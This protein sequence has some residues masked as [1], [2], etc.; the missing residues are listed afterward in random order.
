MARLQF[1]NTTDRTGIIEL[2]ERDTNTQSATASSYPLKVKTVDVN[3]ALGSFALLAIKASGR[4]QW[5]DTNQTDYPV[6]TTNIVSAQQDYTLLYDGATIP[7]QILDLYTVRV[8]NSAGVFREIK[9]IDRQTFDITKWDG[10]TGEPQEYDLTSDGIV[11]YPTPNYNSTNGIE[12]YVA[13]N[14]CHVC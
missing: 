2:I 13:R 9:M 6:L 4:W 8:K 5:D 1:S 12:V 11:L 3:E 7:N 10:Q 14:L